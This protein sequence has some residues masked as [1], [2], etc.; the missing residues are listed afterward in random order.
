[1]VL[2]VV[3]RRIME[4]WPNNC[5]ELLTTA[6]RGSRKNLRPRGTRDG[7]GRETGRQ[8]TR[9][10]APESTRE[11]ESTRVREHTNMNEKTRE[12]TR[13][14]QVSADEDTASSD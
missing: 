2:A 8:G 10:R 13:R 4:I 7:A 14:V 1:M 3:G 6:E 5:S 12:S 9:D 11:Y